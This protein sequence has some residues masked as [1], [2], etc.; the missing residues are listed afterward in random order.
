MVYTSQTA[1]YDE[2]TTSVHNGEKRDN[3]KENSATHK[4]YNQLKQP[5]KSKFVASCFCSRRPGYYLTNVYSFNFLIT[6][7][8]LTLFVIDVKMADRRISG[9]FTLILTSFSFK[10]VTSKTLPTISYLTSL[11]KYQIINIVYLGTC[12]VWHSICSSLDI[13]EVLKIK[14]DKIIMALLATFFILIQIVF[15]VTLLKSYRK[16]KKL[17]KKEAEFEQMIENYPFLEEYDE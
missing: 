5:I 2:S 3:P 8:S 9:T 7:L 6:I 15:M 1:S 12:C 10:I 16:I 4:K 11:D 14:L 13:E 17:E